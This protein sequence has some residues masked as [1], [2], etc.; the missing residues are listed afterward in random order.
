[1]GRSVSAHILK[2]NER[3]ESMLQEDWLL[4]R[5]LRLLRRPWRSHKRGARDRE[6]LLPGP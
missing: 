6:C 4:A 2:L 1:M 3:S 5:C